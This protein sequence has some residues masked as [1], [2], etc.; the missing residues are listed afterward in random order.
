MIPHTCVF[1]S[2]SRSSCFLYDSLQ[3]L[4]PYTCNKLWKNADGSEPFCHYLSSFSHGLNLPQE[5]P[6]CFT[7]SLQGIK[8]LKKSA[9][10]GCRF[11]FA[12]LLY[13]QNKREHGTTLAT[14]CL[15][16]V[17]VNTCQQ[18]DVRPYGSDDSPLGSNHFNGTGISSSA[19]LQH[20]WHLSNLV[21]WN[22]LQRFAYLLG[23]P[24]CWKIIINI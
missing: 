22:V 9:P 4:L 7:H 17:A 24:V 8:R 12:D 5:W 6:A 2:K 1:L 10:P 13:D 15:E 18:S 11:V 16:L 20:V 21:V 14:V 3:R 23:N 19:L